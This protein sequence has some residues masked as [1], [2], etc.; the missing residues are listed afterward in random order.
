MPKTDTQ[1]PL[2]RVNPFTTPSNDGK[3]QIW[4]SKAQRLRSTLFS[5]WL[6]MIDF[7]LG[8]VHFPYRVIPFSGCASGNFFVEHF[9]QI[10]CDVSRFRRS[11]AR[12]HAKRRAKG[13]IPRSDLSEEFRNI[14][15]R[16]RGGMRMRIVQT[17]W[18][19]AG[20]LRDETQEVLDVIRRAAD[21]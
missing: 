10:T 21:R 5:T 16:S 18:T 3:A 20:K 4:S 19:N 1:H 7:K 12:P 9:I 14:Q 13:F 8:L 6:Q 11:Q 2:R 17:G 15:I